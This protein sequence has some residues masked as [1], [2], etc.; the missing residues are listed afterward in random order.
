ME[1]GFP[2]AT[3]KI[4]PTALGITKANLEYNLGLFAHYVFNWATKVRQE[5]Y[6][7]ALL[8]VIPNEIQYCTI[9][10]QIILR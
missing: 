10:A 2:E 6:P 7:L 5:I 4:S 3:L 9:K 8:L 1:I